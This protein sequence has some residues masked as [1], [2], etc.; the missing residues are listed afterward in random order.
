MAVS[1]SY[2]YSYTHFSF[3]R[4]GLELKSVLAAI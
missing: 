4:K 1:Y 2:T 3:F